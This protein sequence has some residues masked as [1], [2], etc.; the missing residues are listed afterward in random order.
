MPIRCSKR[1]RC[2][3]S[4][5]PRLERH[6]RHDLRIQR[7]WI[8]SL[9]PSPPPIVLVEFGALLWYSS[10]R[11]IILCRDD[12]TSFYAASICH[13]SP[14][15][16]CGGGQQQCRWWAPSSWKYLPPVDHP[17]T[18]PSP[19]DTYYENKTHGKHWIRIATFSRLMF[20][21]FTFRHSSCIMTASWTGMHVIAN[22]TDSLPAKF[23]SEVESKTK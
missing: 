9:S 8:V 20:F 6:S 2:G 7:E 4:Q 10:T 22:F 11:S 12:L 17:K 3:L 15:C 1:T 5:R 19:P 16:W 21:F 18:P 23:D 14:T 13:N